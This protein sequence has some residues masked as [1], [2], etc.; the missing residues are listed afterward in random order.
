MLIP[1][2]PLTRPPRGGLVPQER[3][4]ERVARFNAGEWTLLF[5]VVVGVFHAKQCCKKST[6]KEA[7]DELQSKAGRAL[8]LARVVELSHARRALEGEREA[9]RR[10]GKPSQTKQRSRG[11]QERVSINDGREP[12]IWMWISC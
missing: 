9:V 6:Q 10:F 11:P 8:G 4:K 3:L 1:R 2:L 12:K 5:G 7:T